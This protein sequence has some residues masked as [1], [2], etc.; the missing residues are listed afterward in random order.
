MVKLDLQ[1]ND[2]A[3]HR[4]NFNKQEPYS[5]TKGRHTNRISIANTLSGV[6]PILTVFFLTI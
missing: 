1:N 3:L 6:A 4:S 5:M 2:K